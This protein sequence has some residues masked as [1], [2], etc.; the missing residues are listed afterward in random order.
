MSGMFAKMKQMG[1]LIEKLAK[2]KEVYMEENKKLKEFKQKIEE[3]QKAF[4]IEKTL[5]EIS[6][7]V[8]IPEETKEEMVQ[9]A[10]KYSLENIEAWINWCKAKSFEFAMKK[11]S[12]SDVTKVGMPFPAKTDEKKSSLWD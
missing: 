5:Q 8:I 6:Q 10:E 4:T 3:D 11:N 2:D 12:E 9:E 1:E 7:K